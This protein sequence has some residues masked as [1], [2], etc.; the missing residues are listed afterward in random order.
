LTNCCPNYF[1]CLVKFFK[2]VLTHRVIKHFNVLHQ[3]TTLQPG[4]EKSLLLLSPSLSRAGFPF[5]NNPTLNI[6]FDINY[7]KDHRKTGK[8]HA[9]IEDERKTFPRLDRISGEF[10]FLLPVKKNTPIVEDF[11]HY[12]DKRASIHY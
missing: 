11:F 8:F 1:S 10:S 5:S 3:I 12:S 2:M 6:H 9:S 4:D 7:S